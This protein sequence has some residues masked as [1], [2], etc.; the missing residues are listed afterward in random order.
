MAAFGFGS[1]CLLFEQRRAAVLC[2]ST[3]GRR[4]SAF[5]LEPNVHGTPMSLPHRR[6]TDHN[7]TA[8]N[9]HAESDYYIGVSLALCVIA[10]IPNLLRWVS[11]A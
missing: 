11:L 1:L 5:D 3:T 8:T 4:E 7:A 9:P 2:S 6:W 10:M